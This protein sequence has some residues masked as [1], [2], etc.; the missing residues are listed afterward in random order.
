MT[1]LQ[2]RVRVFVYRYE[3]ARPHYLLLRSAQG[4]EGFWT[5][6]HGPLGFDEQIEGAVRREVEAD[7]GPARPKRLVDLQMPSRW[8]VGDEQIIEWNFGFHTQDVGERVDLN[9]DR[10]SGFR[11][12][13]FGE[14][15]P[16]LELEFDRAAILR[17]HSILHAA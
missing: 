8:T 4:I 12:L 15:Y 16:T 11:W 17:L 7:I 9:E 5:P 6:L 2:H 3:D 1:D 14:A 10:W 13:D